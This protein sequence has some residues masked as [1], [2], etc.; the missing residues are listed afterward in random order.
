VDRTS[1][2]LHLQDPLAKPI[3]TRQRPGADDLDARTGNVVAGRSH[4]GVVVAPEETQHGGLQEGCR[5]HCPVK[6]G[7]ED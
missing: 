7:L 1:L 3:L 6:S 2:L 5:C 4:A